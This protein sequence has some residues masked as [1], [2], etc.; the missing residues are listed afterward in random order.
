[1]S[2][3]S[4]LEWI[5]GFGYLLNKKIKESKKANGRDVY[6]LTVNGSAKD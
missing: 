4:V 1:M 5:R 2:H 6:L 3:E